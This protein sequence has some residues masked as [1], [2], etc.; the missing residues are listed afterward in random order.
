[1]NDNAPLL[2]TLCKRV[3]DSDVFIFLFSIIKKNISTLMGVV[4]SPTGAT[5]V[6]LEMDEY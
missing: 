4:C 3:T 5:I 2:M 1:M 6:V